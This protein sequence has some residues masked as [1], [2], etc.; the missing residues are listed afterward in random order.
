[1][2]KRSKVYYRRALG[3]EPADAVCGRCLRTL[4]A[5]VGE[6][7]GASS[8]STLSVGYIL[9]CASSVGTVAGLSE[10]LNLPLIGLPCVS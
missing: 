8:C 10:F 4:F 3:L 1:M 9:G 6:Y 5:D 7:F 2:F